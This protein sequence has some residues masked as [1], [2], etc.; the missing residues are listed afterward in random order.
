MVLDMLSLVLV[1]FVRGTKGSTQFKL[2]DS[3]RR[4]RCPKCGWEPAKSD[5]WSCNPGGCGHVWNTF[6]TL[7]RC[8]SCD[9]F[10][11]ETACLR[12]GQWSEHDAWY[13]KTSEPGM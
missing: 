2:D 11:N 8:P 13:D 1:A 6:D 4:I 7:G 5:R 3:N 12:C 9:R 10:W